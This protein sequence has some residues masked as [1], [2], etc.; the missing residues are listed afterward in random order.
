MPQSGRRSKRTAKL[1]FAI[2]HLPFAVLPRPPRAWYHPVMP[3]TV[4]LL[5][6]YHTGSHRAWAEGYAAHSRHDVR[7]LA[8]QGYF[9][10]W[11]MQGARWSWPNRRKPRWQPARGPTCCWRRA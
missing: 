1:P 11:R 3:L 2:C 5:N 7:V 9:W 10:K 6:P 4:W 8:M